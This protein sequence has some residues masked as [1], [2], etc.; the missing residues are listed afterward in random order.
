MMVLLALAHCIFKAL[1]GFAMH[2]QA[3][4]PKVMCMQG[5]HFAEH[6]YVFVLC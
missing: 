6:V 2:T 5:E 1:S 3:L 4:C